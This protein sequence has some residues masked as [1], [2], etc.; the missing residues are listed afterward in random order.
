MSPGKSTSSFKAQLE[1]YFFQQAFTAPLPSIC[2]HSP[3]LGL[4]RLHGAILPSSFSHLCVGPCVLTTRTTF[5]SCTP[6]SS[7]V[8]GLEEGA[9]QEIFMT[10][11]QDLSASFRPGKQKATRERLGDHRVRGSE[12]KGRASARS[13]GAAFPSLDSGPGGRWVQWGCLLARPCHHASM[14][15]LARVPY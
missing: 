8:P 12:G 3:P 7:T 6:V 9:P 5:R 14:L 10:S 15:G 2:E 1:C 11:G 4:Q 13:K